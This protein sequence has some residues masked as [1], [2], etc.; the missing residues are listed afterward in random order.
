MILKMHQNKNAVLVAALYMYCTS[1]S[2]CGSAA[3]L[4]GH[5]RRLLVLCRQRALW[6]HRRRLVCP[7]QRRGPRRRRPPGTLSA[8]RSAGQ[9]SPPRHA[10]GRTEMTA[11]SAARSGQGVSASSPSTTEPCALRRPIS[12]QAFGQLPPWRWRTAPA[13]AAFSACSELRA[14][15]GRRRRFRRSADQPARPAPAC[16]SGLAQTPPHQ[17]GMLVIA[18]ARNSRRHSWPGGSARVMKSAMDSSPAAASRCGTARSAASTGHS[19]LVSGLWATSSSPP[20]SLCSWSP[21]RARGQRSS[22][23]TRCDGGLHCNLICI[24]LSPLVSEALGCSST[25]CSAGAM[26]QGGPGR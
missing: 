3:Y 15:R 22:T 2:S 24:I 14:G 16:R 18:G 1:R 6:V 10:R 20:G 25:S 13:P 11:P 21:G 9:L 19:Q 8:A 4:E 5:Q 7:H 23:P 17:G 12:G 26:Q